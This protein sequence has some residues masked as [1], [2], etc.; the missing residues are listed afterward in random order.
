[1]SLWTQSAAVRA[2]MEKF[3]QQ[4]VRAERQ[5]QFAKRSQ[6]VA[7]FQIFAIFKVDDLAC[8]EANLVV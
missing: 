7:V 5:E 4:N 3:R 8:F 2:Q 6:Q 1:M